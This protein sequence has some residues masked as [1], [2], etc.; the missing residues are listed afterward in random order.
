[1]LCKCFVQKI[2]GSS[3]N[4]PVLNEC[5]ELLRLL[6][7]IRTYRTCWNKNKC[8]KWVWLHKCKALWSWKFYSNPKGNVPQVLKFSLYPWVSQ[9]ISTFTSSYKRLQL[10][11][12]VFFSLIT[13][14]WNSLKLPFPLSPTILKTFRVLNHLPVTQRV[15]L[16]LH[17]YRFCHFK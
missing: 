14:C 2:S 16:T 13:Y 15:R 3:C 1:M 8:L 5:L 12:F 9:S 6:G 11:L 4:L 10:H 17:A 7:N